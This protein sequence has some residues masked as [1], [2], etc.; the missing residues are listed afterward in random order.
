MFRISPIALLI[1]IS[2]PPAPAFSDDNTVCSKATADLDQR[3]AACTNV[4]ASKNLKEQNKSEA[5]INRGAAYYRKHDYD[6]ALEDYNE[7]IRHDPHS[8]CR[9][10]DRSLRLTDRPSRSAQILAGRVA[11]CASGSL[12]FRNGT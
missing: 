12:P 9:R 2:L 10:S 7:A 8:D 11:V 4:I 6:R 3:I 1:V 5:F